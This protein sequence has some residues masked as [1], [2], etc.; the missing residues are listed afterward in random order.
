MNTNRTQNKQLP[1][2]A[3]MQSVLYASD[4]RV[5]NYVLDIDDNVLSISEI[6]KDYISFNNCNLKSRYS[7]IKPIPLTE[8]WLFKFGFDF[9]K[10]K[11]HRKSYTPEHYNLNNFS[12]LISNKGYY[13]VSYIPVYIFFVHQLQNLY[14]ALTGAELTVA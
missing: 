14:F 8:E 11:K 5:G 4:L 12:L 6:T 3:V 10:M 2:D 1:Q 13:V 7:K 9:K